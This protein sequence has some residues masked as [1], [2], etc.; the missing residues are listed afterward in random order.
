[1]QE[2]RPVAY[3]SKKLN[4]AQMNYTT[5]EKELLSIVMTLTEFRSMLL[6]ADIT[7]H[8]DH[9]NLTFDSLMT[10]RFLRWRCYVEEYSPTIK[11]IKGPFNVTAD[12]FYNSK[13]RTPSKL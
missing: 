9:K 1:M 13:E 12:T 2:A 7:V 10:Q 6:G 3:Y 5:M 8:T 4:S 11:Y